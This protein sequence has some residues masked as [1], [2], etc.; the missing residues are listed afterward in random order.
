M[1]KL[2]IGPMYS[3]FQNK[4][5]FTNFRLCSLRRVKDLIAKSSTSPISFSAVGRPGQSR[6]WPDW[7]HSVWESP[8][9]GCNILPYSF[10]AVLDQ[11]SSLL[12]CELWFVTHAGPRA[13]WSTGSKEPELSSEPLLSP[14]TLASTSL[15]GSEIKGKDKRFNAD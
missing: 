15:S 1:L 4:R 2:K 12:L 10:R 7:S 14:Q 6:C 13:L 8:S 11:V 9:S 3:S 5:K